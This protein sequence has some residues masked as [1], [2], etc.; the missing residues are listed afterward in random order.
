[1]KQLHEL[2]E[3]VT[4]VIAQ[5]TELKEQ[6]ACLMQESELLAEKAVSLAQENALLQEKIAALTQENAAI[7]L[8]FDEAQTQAIQGLDAIVERDQLSSSISELLAS[9]ETINNQRDAL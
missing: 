6:V 8:K 4:K 1:M 7:L 9:I 2:A 5:N 3:K